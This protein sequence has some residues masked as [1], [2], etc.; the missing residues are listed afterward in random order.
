[1]T[2]FQFQNVVETYLAME[3]SKGNSAQA[4]IKAVCEATGRKYNDKYLSTWPKQMTAV[5]DD[6]C[7]SCRPSHRHHSTKPAD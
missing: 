7:R 5:P 3:K 4:A 2:D 6:V 1:M